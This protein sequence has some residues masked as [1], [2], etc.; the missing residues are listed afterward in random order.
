MNVSTLTLTCQT[1]GAANPRPLPY[2]MVAPDQCDDCDAAF[3]KHDT[4]ARKGDWMQTFT[5]RQYWPLDP[6]AGDVD[7]DD[8]AHHL[9]MICR[10]CGACS[11]HYSVAE[12]SVYVSRLVPPELALPALLHDASE[13]YC[14]DIVRPVKRHL[15]GYAAIE[16]ANEA[17]IFAALDVPEPTPG[18]WAL[19]KEADNAILL[20]EQALLMGPA[21]AS[22]SPLDVPQ[23]LVDKALGLLR[24]GVAP[25][26]PGAKYL[27]LHRYR[28]LSGYRI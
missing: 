8:I 6:R 5:G 25:T 11:R 13:A 23:V 4:T 18:Q 22:W 21:P 10:F 2:D 17:A 19:I 3:A 24:A 26:P 16:A 28:E 7:I 27:F 1:C 12:H 9:A 15:P 20:A 14:N